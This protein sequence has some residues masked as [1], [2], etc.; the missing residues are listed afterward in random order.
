METK[1][2]ILTVW[3]VGFVTGHRAACHCVSQPNQ[4]GRHKI[5]PFH[6]IFCYPNYSMKDFYNSL[7]RS[8]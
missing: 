8:L 2:N 6:C 4:P 1:Q 5:T 7:G 3:E